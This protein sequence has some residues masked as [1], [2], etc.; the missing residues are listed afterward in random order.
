M[1]ISRRWTPPRKTLISIR[2]EDDL[3]A[4]YRSLGPGWQRVANEALRAYLS[5]LPD[6][7][8]DSPSED[9]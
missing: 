7:R 8:V 2:L 5:E 3:L 4:A 9:R 6:E 1:R